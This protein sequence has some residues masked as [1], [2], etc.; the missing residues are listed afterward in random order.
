VGFEEQIIRNVPFENKDLNVPFEALII[1]Y[2]LKY[3]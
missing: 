3:R 2:L 1:K